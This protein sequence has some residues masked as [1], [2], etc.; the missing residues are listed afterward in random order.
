RVRPLSCRHQPRVPGDAE[1]TGRPA[2]G[3]SGRAAL[4]GPAAPPAPADRGAADTF[5][6]HDGGLRPGG[7]GRRPG[8]L[9]GGRP[10]HRRAPGAAARGF[11]GVP[12]RGRNP[13][14][15]R[16]RGGGGPS[17]RGGWWR[18]GF[19]APRRASL[20]YGEDV[21]PASLPPAPR[22]P[23]RSAARVALPGIPPCG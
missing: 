21:A 23:P 3:P 2:R 14:G 6:G 13:P 9:A 10:L 4:P 11:G 22:F 19:F 18:G 15:G 17:P 12:A 1:P 7:A 8:V 5:S 20:D 16:T